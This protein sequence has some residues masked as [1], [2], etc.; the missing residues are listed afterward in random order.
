[1]EPETITGPDG[2]IWTR[3]ADRTTLTSEDGGKVI[4]NADM[5]TE[6]LLS[7]AYQSEA[8]DGGETV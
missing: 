7:V 2:K 6:Y 1:M 4:G 8:T 5:S 3:S